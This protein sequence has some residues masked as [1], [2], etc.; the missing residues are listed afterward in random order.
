MQHTG[1]SHVAVINNRH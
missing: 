1:S